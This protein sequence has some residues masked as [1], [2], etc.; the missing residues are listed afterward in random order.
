MFSLKYIKGCSFLIKKPAREQA[1]WEEREMK[2]TMFEGSE[3]EVLILEILLDHDGEMSGKDICKQLDRKLS[4]S[5]IYA[6]LANLEEQGFI[7]SRKKEQSDLRSLPR[8]LYRIIDQGK[9]VLI[10]QALQK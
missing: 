9:R 8:R 10:D 2:R 6:C 5:A 7:A 3:E 1:S 4:F